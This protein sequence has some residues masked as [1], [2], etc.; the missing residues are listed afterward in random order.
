[1]A[2]RIGVLV[3]PNLEDAV[4]AVLLLNNSVAIVFSFIG[5]EPAL[6]ALG[7]IFAISIL[8]NLGS[9]LANPISSRLRLKENKPVSPYLP[10]LALE[11]VGTVTFLILY[12]LAVVVVLDGEYWQTD[13]TFIHAYATVG[14]LVA[15]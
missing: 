11:F 6:I 13:L 1:M 4:R 10:A 15:L 12:I 8:F 9:I 2:S 7:T 14:A 3:A 5:L